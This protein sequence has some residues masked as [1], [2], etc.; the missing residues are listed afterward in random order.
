MGTA[1]AYFYATSEVMA[2]VILLVAKLPAAKQE[3][4]LGRHPGWRGEGWS[5]QS[6]PA[7]F[8]ESPFK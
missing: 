2:G 1:A 6:K 5:T 7:A 3:E 4:A 8:T